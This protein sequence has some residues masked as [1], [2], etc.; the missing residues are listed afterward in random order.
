LDICFIWRERCFIF[1]QE[2]IP[3]WLYC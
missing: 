2:Y 3:S 1:W